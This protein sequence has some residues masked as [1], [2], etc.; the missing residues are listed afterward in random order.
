VRDAEQ[1]ERDYWAN[2]MSTTMT[3]SQV[4]YDFINSAEM[5]ILLQ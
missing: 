5:G 1:W 2:L 3:V 4:F